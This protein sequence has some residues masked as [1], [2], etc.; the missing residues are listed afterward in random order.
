MLYT[1]HFGDGSAPYSTPKQGAPYPKPGSRDIIHR[2]EQA[3]EVSVSVDVTYRAR[4][5]INGGEW[6]EIPE[7]IPTTGSPTVALEVVSG[8]P[9]LVG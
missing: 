6:Q 5:Q 3:D 8:S 9:L 4:F 7:D 2:Y 1:W